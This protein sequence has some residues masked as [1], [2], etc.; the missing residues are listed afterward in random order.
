MPIYATDIQSSIDVNTIVH[1]KFNFNDEQFN[2]KIGLMNREKII[3]QPSLI[4]ISI[5]E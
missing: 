2:T 4:S 5:Q 1:N 3:R